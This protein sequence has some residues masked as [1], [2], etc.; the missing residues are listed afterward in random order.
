MIKKNPYQVKLG[1]VVRHTRKSLKMNQ[2]VFSR[3]MHLT[4][5][6]ISRLETGYQGFRFDVLCRTAR[7]LGS[8]PSKLLAA[9]GL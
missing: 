3:K 8:K 4:Q 1:T 7:I 9:A 2:K 5:A 6:Q